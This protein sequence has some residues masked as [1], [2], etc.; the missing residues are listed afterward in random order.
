MWCLHGLVKWQ[1]NY[2][3]YYIISFQSEWI[4]KQKKPK[5][6]IFGFKN[7]EGKFK[8]HENPGSSTKISWFFIVGYVYVPKFWFCGYL[9]LISSF[10]FSLV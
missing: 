6:W 2:V 1:I 10:L 5:Q 3:A 9:L 7:S 4:E 8:S